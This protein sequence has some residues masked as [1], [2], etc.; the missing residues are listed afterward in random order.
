MRS[1][2]KV[3]PIPRSMTPLIVALLAILL[4]IV[5]V[6]C[7]PNKTQDVADSA[8]A[9]P[10]AS[11]AHASSRPTSTV[12]DPIATQVVRVIDGDTVVVAAVDGV[13]DPTDPAKSPDNAS[14]RLLGIDAPEMNRKT[15]EPD[16]GAQ[17]A[18]D[19]LAALLPQGTSVQITFDATADHYDRYNRALAYI[20]LADG[21]DVN[22]AQLA[23]GFA[24][25]WVPASKPEPA[26]F[27]QY[28]AAA[29]RAQNE[30]LGAYGEPLSCSH[31]G[32]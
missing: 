30:H 6:G 22:L 20:E 29:Q 17:L 31:L 25:A 19:Q 16:C 24:A 12:G 2:R 26:R 18:T 5:I 21:T 8:A 10:G 15:D 9:S 28:T 1:V 23:G 7:D 14:V 27:A 32:R 3:E 4:M 13:L 11:T